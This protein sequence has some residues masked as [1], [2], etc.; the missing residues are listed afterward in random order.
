M[1][2]INE[3]P[4]PTPVAEFLRLVQRGHDSRRIFSLPVGEEF[5]CPRIVDV[6]HAKRPDGFQSVFSRKL[7]RHSQA[8]GFLTEKRLQMIVGKAARR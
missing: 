7:T 8:I 2:E 4:E 5:R 3:T 6:V 1:F